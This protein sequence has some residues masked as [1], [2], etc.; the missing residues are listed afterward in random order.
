MTRPGAD[1]SAANVAA[2]GGTSNNGGGAGGNGG[3]CAMN[4]GPGGPGRNA[5]GDV[6]PE[7]GGGGGGG[8]VGVLHVFGDPQPALPVNAI[9]PCA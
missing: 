8:S 3:A 5:P 9:S 2:A 1:P 7:S 6:T 4:V